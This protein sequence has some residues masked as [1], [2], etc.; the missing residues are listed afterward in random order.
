MPLDASSRMAAS[1]SAA[2]TSADNIATAQ[3]TGDFAIK[4]ETDTPKLDTSNWPLLLKVGWSS[5]V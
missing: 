5:A 4:P 2:V 3:E 1:T